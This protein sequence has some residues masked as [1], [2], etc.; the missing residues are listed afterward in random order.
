M[1]SRFHAQYKPTLHCPSSVSNTN[2]PCIVPVPCIVQTRLM[3]SRSQL[4]CAVPL[5]RSAQTHLVLSNFRAQYK[6]QAPSHVR[7]KKSGNRGSECVQT[8][9][10]C[11]HAQYKPTLYCPSSVHN[12]NPP[13]AVPVPYTIQPTLCCP[14]SVHNTNP[15]CAVPV[16]C[17]IQTHLVLSQ[18]RARYKPTLCCPSSVHDTNP[19]CSVPVPCTIQTHLVLSQFRAQYKLTLCCPSSSAMT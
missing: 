15:P 13:C 11:W 18:F 5:P 9:S 17:T 4:S 7:W 8:Y 10:L 14:S 12:K 16:P 2:Q 3:L 19:P 6:P 1:V